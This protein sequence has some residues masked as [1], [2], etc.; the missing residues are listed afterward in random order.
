MHIG[1]FSESGTF[2]G[3]IEKIDHLKALGVTHLELM[4]IAAFPGNHGWGYDGVDL[5]APHAPYG[6]PEDLKHLIDTCHQKGLAVILDVVYN[7]LGPDGNYLGL[8]G[9]YFSGRYRT[10]W[11][12]AINFDAANSDEVRR[13]I[14]NNALYWLN[15][16]H[17]DGLRLDAVHAIFD[18][19]AT[20]ILEEL[21]LKVE[22]LGLKTGR[23]LFLIAESDLNDPRLLYS[24]EKGGYGLEA[25][26]LDDFHHGL[27]VML[28]GEQQGYYCDF[29]GFA[30]LQKCLEQKY[31]YAGD[32]SRH[33]QR[34]H[35]RLP[36][37][38]G[39]ERFIVSL[40]NHDQ[41]GNRALG[42]RISHLTDLARCQAAAALMLLSP[43]VPMLFQGEEWAA[44]SP[45]LY[46][47]DHVDKNLA[48]AV[49]EGRRKEFPFIDAE[50]PDP[51]AEDT[52]LRSQLN[53]NEIEQAE[54]KQMLEWYQAL[55]KI[56]NEHLEEIRNSRPALSLISRQGM[57]IKYQAG[58][59]ELLANCENSQIEVPGPVNFEALLHN[60]EFSRAKENL[61]LP[62]NATIVLKTLVNKA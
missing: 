26:W 17:F 12:E 15:E 9:P 36:T 51:Q 19:S 43:F 53:W 29:S 59:I 37:D 1:T 40:Q 46:F 20:H 13:F 14:T 42:E 22:E 55:I 2:C 23:E 44:S 54:H 32:Y 45:F 41:I 5:F 50:V 28:T 56:R 52:F 24:R 39:Y 31:V 49:K 34:R 58:T 11:G 62:P 4:P 33:R 3:V 35:G 25:Q 47:T 60:K 30:D 8:Y 16:F 57:V 21:Q 7:H 61:I 10:P 38:L 18:F 48:E 27:H 6:N